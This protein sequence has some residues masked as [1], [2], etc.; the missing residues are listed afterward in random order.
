MNP[1]RTL[2]PIR[3]AWLLL[4]AGAVHAAALAQTATVTAS[5]PPAAAT[6]PANAPDACRLMPR[7]DIEALFP[8]RP[9][10]DKGPTLSPLSRGPQYAESCAYVVRLPSPT[11]TLDFAR[12]ASLTVVRWGD[13]PV[14]GR[15]TAKDSFASI[16]TARERVATDPKLSLR[17]EPLAGVGEEAFMETSAHR[18]A[19]YARKGDLI[20]SASLDAYSS[21]TPGNASALARQALSR[22]QPGT[23]MVAAAAPIAT[24]AALE[25]PADTRVSQTAPADQWPDACALMTPEDVKA[26]FPDMTIAAPVQFKGKI[27][28]ES[29]ENRIEEIPRPIGCLYNVRRTDTLDGKR[30]TVSHQVQ[31]SVRNLASTP[32]FS[33]RYFEVSKKV[34]EPKTPVAGLGDEA[35]IDILNRIQIRK[36]LL[37]VEVRVGGGER[38]AALHAV[39]RERVN[40]LAARVAAKLP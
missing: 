40:A 26:V 31:M 8:G 3:P 24:Q 30:V 25:V 11:S 38:D 19:V 18:V 10:T 23:G 4:L 13:S 27:T 12:F 17:I 14:V 36:G 22:W 21:Q 35:N 15:G 2:A 32:A 6:A 33:Q 37:S 28:H 5:P 1:F 16:R 29:R 34:G 39:A 7:A 20:V 9:V